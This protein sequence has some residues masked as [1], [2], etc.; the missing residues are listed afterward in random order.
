M[1]VLVA[2][3]DNDSIV[4]ANVYHCSKEICAVCPTMGAVR[5][6]AASSTPLPN[7]ISWRFCQRRQQGSDFIVSCGVISIR[8]SFHSNKS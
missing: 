7:I 4:D 8:S 2:V 3:C 5:S 1:S 6:E